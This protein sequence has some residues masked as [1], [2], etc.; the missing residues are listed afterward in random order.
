MLY[1]ETR[2]K[3]KSVVYIVV[4]QLIAA[5]LLMAYE[6]IVCFVA[7]GVVVTVF[8][9]YYRHMS[10]EKF[11]GVTGDTAGWFLTLCETVAVVVLAVAVYVLH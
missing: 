3:K 7:V 1:E 11:G 4:V 6:S 5:S 9:V 8:T 2:G 10:Y